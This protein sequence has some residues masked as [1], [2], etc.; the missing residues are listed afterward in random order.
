LFFLEEMDGKCLDRNAGTWAHACVN[1]VLDLVI[2]AVPIIQ[3]WMMQ[4]SYSTRKKIQVIIMFSV[5]IVV[6]IC[7]VLRLRSL[8]V[9]MSSHN[10]TV[11]GMPF[12]TVEPLSYD[13]Q[14]DNL[15]CAEWSV[16][17]IQ[18]GIICAC[19]PAARI[20]FGRMVPKLLGVTSQDSRA[21]PSAPM[22]LDATDS[23]RPPRSWNRITTEERLSL[24]GAA[25]MEI[26]YS[27]D[28]VVLEDVGNVLGSS[29]G[30]EKGRVTTQ[31]SPLN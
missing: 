7:S 2:L 6:T 21:T 18:V 10:P 29:Q 8:I 14:Y 27:K 5:G 13:L 19:L 20:F 30:S 25:Q 31:H 3:L 9:F 28:F 15:G 26:N 24:H 1:I 12:S 16:V 4:T 23:R 11:S 17:E 22:Y